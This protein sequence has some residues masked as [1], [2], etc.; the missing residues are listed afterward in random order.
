MEPQC[1]RYT[2]CN[3]SREQF[4]H[5]E[6]WQPWGSNVHEY[7]LREKNVSYF[8]TH[9]IGDVHSGDS[10]GM[11]DCLGVRWKSWRQT[12]RF[13]Y[14]DATR[15]CRMAERY[16]LG[17]QHTEADEEVLNGFRHESH[18]QEYTMHWQTVWRESGNVWLLMGP[19][20]WLHTK[21]WLCTGWN[22]SPKRQSITHWGLSSNLPCR[23]LTQGL[24]SSKFNKDKTAIFAQ[25]KK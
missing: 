8:L 10:G 6:W 4:Y 5:S 12:G 18:R 3:K 13:L 15:D 20:L 11:A 9:H 21:C 2:L 14:S 17:R 24:N 7:V 25:H 22:I 16:V 19:R 23:Y 1:V